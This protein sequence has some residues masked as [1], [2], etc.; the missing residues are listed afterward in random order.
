MNTMHA[1]TRPQHQ[2]QPSPEEPIAALLGFAVVEFPSDRGGWVL[3][4]EC[5]WGVEFL[6][7]E[8]CFQAAV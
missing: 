3:R 7:N 2:Q 1:N 8:G 6:V 4:G 5:R